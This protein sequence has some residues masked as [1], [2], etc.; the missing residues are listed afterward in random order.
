MDWDAG[1]ELEWTAPLYRFN[2]AVPLAKAFAAVHDERFAQAFVELTS[3]WIAK[4]PLEIDDDPHALRFYGFGFAWY[5]IQVGLRAKQLCAAFPTFVH[6]H[7]FTP[8]FLGV[9]LAS[10]YDHAAKV[11]KP[12]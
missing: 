8:E 10:L 11:L 1:P 6:S 5:P 9:F 12:S 7:A 4:H 3:D 2:W